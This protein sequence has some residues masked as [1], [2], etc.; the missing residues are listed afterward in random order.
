MIACDM[1]QN[2]LV[3]KLLIMSPLCVTKQ[4]E[5]ALKQLK[6]LKLPNEEN[7]FFCF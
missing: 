7:Y 3:K 6:F 2:N 4:V 5:Q 1:D